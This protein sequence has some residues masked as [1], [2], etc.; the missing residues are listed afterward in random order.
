MGAG[1]G[2]GEKPE[3]LQG[4]RTRDDQG[5]GAPYAARARGLHRARAG[6]AAGHAG[7]RP[8][9][10]L[11][12]GPASRARAGA[13][14]AARRGARGPVA[15]L[16]P[17][18]RRAGPS[19]ISG[20]RAGRAVEPIQLRPMTR[21]DLAGLEELSASRNVH[22]RE[23]ERFMGLE[24]AHGLVLEKGSRLLGAI[25]VMRYFEHGFLG[26]ILLR[27][28]EDGVGLSLALLARAIEGLQRAGVTLI[29]AE[30]TGDEA[31]LL[32]NLG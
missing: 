17:A 22:R 19:F 2:E 21:A 25:T 20:T 27:P 32:S 28:S 9:D 3:V 1:L 8:L 14:R 23:Y 29:E 24:G 7:A 31:V 18:G 5:N 11:Q 13:G 16:L 15:P 10:R 4:K 6:N 26:P 12:D 30:A